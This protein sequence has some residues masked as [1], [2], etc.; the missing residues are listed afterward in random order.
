MSFQNFAFMSSSLLFQSTLFARVTYSFSFGTYSTEK[1]GTY[2]ISLIKTCF[3]PLSCV[4]NLPFSVKD[5]LNFE[6]ANGF[7][8]QWILSWFFK[9]ILCIK[10]LRFLNTQMAFPLC[11]SFHAFSN[12]L[13][14][15]KKWDLFHF[16]HKTHFAPK[17][18][19]A[20]C[21]LTMWQ[22]IKTQEWFEK[23]FLKCNLML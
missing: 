5:L 23:H 4:F 1:N 2:S 16:T 13:F 17:W 18:R 22:N 6:Q 3:A 7:S 9:A 19:K 8:L 14:H 20:L 15:W 11:G 21:L 10:W 12:D